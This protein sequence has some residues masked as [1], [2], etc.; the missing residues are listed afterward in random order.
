ML[1]YVMLG[2]LIVYFSSD[3]PSKKLTLPRA[4]KTLEAVAVESRIGRTDTVLSAIYRPPRPSRKGRKMPPED[5][6]LQKVEEEINNICQ[7]ASFQKQTIVTAKSRVQNQISV[8]SKTARPRQTTDRLYNRR[9][10]DNA[11]LTFKVKH[12]LIPV[13]ISDLLI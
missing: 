9:L 11:T 13:N 3:I 7:W 2:G 10:Q 5:K 4:Y 12:S 1:C 6:Y 8:L